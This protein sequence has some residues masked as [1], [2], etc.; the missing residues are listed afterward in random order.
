MNL[1][2]LQS[3]SGVT[4]EEN[5]SFSKCTTFQLGGNCP[6]LITCSA[7]AQ[8]ENVIKFLRDKSISFIVIGEGSNLVVSDSGVKNVIVRF[9]SKEPDIQ[10]NGCKI[11]APSGTS[12]DEVVLFAAQNGLKGLNFASGIPGTVGGAV[13]GN[14]G[15]FGQQI[16]D[17]LFY[18]KLLGPTGKIRIVEPEALN[19]NYRD[20]NIAQNG[21]IILSVTFALLPEDPDALLYERKNILKERK[22]KHPDYK[23]IPCAGSFFK[24]IESEDGR[25]AAGALLDQAGAKEMMVGGAAVFEKHANIIVKKSKD[26][27]SQDIFDLS[28]KMAES[29]EKKFGIE[30]Q[31]EVL[32]VGEFKDGKNQLNR[33]IW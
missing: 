24:N 19:F 1:L 29:V 3:I 11:T 10:L 8:F 12:L 2:S 27:S 17:S 13:C 7:V 31:R 23:K 21:D 33:C 22:E 14:A 4:V 5:A 20:S 25:K 15:A 9:V 18:I 6:F 26:C 32:F 30:L 28:Q 16:S